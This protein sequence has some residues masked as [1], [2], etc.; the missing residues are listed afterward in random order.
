MI[1]TSDPPSL[2]LQVDLTHSLFV[3]PVHISLPSLFLSQSLAT[4]SQ[5]P[6]WFSPSRGKTRTSCLTILLSN[7]PH[8]TQ[9]GNV[10]TKQTWQQRKSRCSQSNPPQCTDCLAMKKLQLSDLKRAPHA[11][12]FH[13]ESRL[14]FTKIWCVFRLGKSHPGSIKVKFP[15]KTNQIC[16]AGFFNYLTWVCLWW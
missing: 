12:R 5:I 2:E 6:K 9:S 10:A 7:P 13:L 1:F 14:L 3:G 4:E 15:A 16:K 11:A 8:S